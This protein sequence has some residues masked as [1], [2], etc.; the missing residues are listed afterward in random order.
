MLSEGATAVFIDGMNQAFFLIIL[1]INLIIEK[2]VQNYCLVWILGLEKNTNCQ[3]LQKNVEKF[4]PIVQFQ[5]RER[6]QEK[7]N[8][9][10]ASADCA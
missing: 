1:T 2:L 4:V 9:T 5:E 8:W 3:I 6:E 7:K 10:K